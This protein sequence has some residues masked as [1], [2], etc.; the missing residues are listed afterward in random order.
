MRYNLYAYNGNDAFGIYSIGY[1]DDKLV[2]RFGPAQRNNYIIHY[3]LSGHG[4]FNNH[5][6]K[7]GQGFLI[8]PG[9][10]EHYYPDSKTPWAFLWIIL[11][12]S[13]NNNAIFKEYNANPKTNIFEYNNIYQL[14][15]MKDIIIKN[16]DNIYNSSEL[17]EMFLHIFNNHNI[18]KNEKKDAES[19]YYHYA[20]N[21]I[22]SNIFRKI[23]IDELTNILGISQPYLYKI[24]IKKCSMSPKNYID[25][26]KIQ[27]AMELLLETSMPLTEIAH[28]IGIEDG[29][30]LS[31]FFKK[32]TGLSPTEFRKNN[33]R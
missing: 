22:N 17:F 13:V 11:N 30:S 18:S 3:V 5:I 26:I 19:M 2:T 24:F 29:I 16:N 25:K 21:F 14:I 8:T 23:T 15:Q 6:V 20:V 10:S 28:S 33:T 9:M 31:K 12:D 32:K 4:Y 27:K 1:S 7:K